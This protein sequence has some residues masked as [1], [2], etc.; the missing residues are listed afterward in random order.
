[1]ELLL[2]ME[3]LQDMEHPLAMEL[4]LDTVLPLDMELHLDIQVPQEHLQEDLR[5]IMDNIPL[6]PMDIH[7]QEEHLPM[8][9]LLLL[10]LLLNIPL[11]DLELP[12]DQE[13]QLHNKSCKMTLYSIILISSNSLKDVNVHDNEFE[14]LWLKIHNILIYCV[15]FLINN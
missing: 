6:H 12:V 4:H 3:V 2:G 11:E 9:D 14:R 5:G 13:H 8:E 10:V 15:E 1:M 7:D